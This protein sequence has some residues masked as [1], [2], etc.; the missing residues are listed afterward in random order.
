MPNAKILK[1]TKK[2]AREEHRAVIDDCKDKIL[3]YMGHRRRVI[4]QRNRIAQVMDGMEE[5]T[6]YIILDYKMKFNALKFREKTVD[7]F[8]KRGMSWHGAMTYMKTTQAEQ[9]RTDHI[10]AGDAKQDRW[11]VLSIVESMSLSNLTMLPATAMVI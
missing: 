5:D 7:H 1:Y 4:N 2:C 8:G 11:A 10:S 9:G 3:L 6:A